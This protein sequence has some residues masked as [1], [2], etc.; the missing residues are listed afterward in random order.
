[1]DT[2]Q[3]IITAAIFTVLGYFFAKSDYERNAYSESKRITQLTIETLIR[4]GYLKT[5]GEGDQAEL[6]KFD[7]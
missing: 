2:T 3:F 5:R 1:M 7:E 4:M 6:V